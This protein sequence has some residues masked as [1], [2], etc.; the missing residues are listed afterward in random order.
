MRNL[1]YIIITINYPKFTKFYLQPTNFKKEKDKT[2]KSS[3]IELKTPS[4]Y[5]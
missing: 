1:S 4:D 3:K 5:K 2:E